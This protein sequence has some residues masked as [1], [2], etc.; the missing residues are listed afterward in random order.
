[1]DKPPLSIVMHILQRIKELEVENEDLRRQ[2]HKSKSGE[3]MHALHG[4]CSEN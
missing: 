2:L 4:T 3:L 1:M